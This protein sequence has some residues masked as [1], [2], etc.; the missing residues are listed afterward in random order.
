M[1]SFLDFLFTLLLAVVTVTFLIM[2][3]EL[4]FPVNLDSKSLDTKREVTVRSKAHW[5]R[6]KNDVQDIEI[7]DRRK[8]KLTNGNT[9][10]STHNSVGKNGQSLQRWKNVIVSNNTPQNGTMLNSNL[11][12]KERACLSSISMKYS[13][14]D[15]TMSKDI[16]WCKDTMSKHSVVTGRSWG[17]LPGHLRIKWDTVNCNE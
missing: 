2:T 3:T 1:R 12:S 16:E 10:S 7:L 4:M 11:E 5:Q 17:S 15:E 13:T 9:A 8:Q 6:G 14:V